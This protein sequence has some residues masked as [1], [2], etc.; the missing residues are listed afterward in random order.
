MKDKE[1]I[2]NFLAQEYGSECLKDPLSEWTKEREEQF[3]E[4][5][6]KMISN[7][8]QDK[9]E[10]KNDV[11]V[12]DQMVKRKKKECEKCKKNVFTNRDTIYITKHKVCENCYIVFYEGR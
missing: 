4:E 6:S 7:Q 12:I 10:E 8:K 9:I 5:Y 11:I 1:Q 3:L 2:N